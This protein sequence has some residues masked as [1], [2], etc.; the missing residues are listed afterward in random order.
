MQCYID[1]K[2]LRSCYAVKDA[3]ATQVLLYSTILVLRFDDTSI[4]LHDTSC[5]WLDYTSIMARRLRLGITFHVTLRYNYH[6]IPPYWY[7]GSTILVSR[8]TILVVVDLTI[9]V[10]LLDDYGLVSRF[11]LLYDTI[12]TLFHHT[13]I[14]VRRY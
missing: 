8:S 14:T 7:Y 9:L 1:A 10:S 13:G 5:S 4:T 2:L 11:T 6:F 3:D 12:I